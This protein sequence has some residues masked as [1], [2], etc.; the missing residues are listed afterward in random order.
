[1]AMDL[2]NCMITVFILFLL[3]AVPVF[4]K[5][6]LN[7]E[8]YDIDYRGPETHSHRPPPNRTGSGVPHSNI[9][10][11]PRFKRQTTRNAIKKVRSLYVYMQ[12]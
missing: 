2:K 7:S 5:E 12:T 6:G 1:M 11:H 9:K 10:K 4:S 8:V 3:L